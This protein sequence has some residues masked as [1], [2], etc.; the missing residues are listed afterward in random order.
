MLFPLNLEPFD[1]EIIVN[2]SKGAP[3]VSGEGMIHWPT[4][5]NSNVRLALFSRF[6]H[7]IQEVN[8]PDQASMS[9]QVVRKPGE[10][11]ALSM[12]IATKS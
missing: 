3:A 6:V 2:G 11:L 12:T 5:P 7:F 4:G 9:I 1:Y 10:R 8:I